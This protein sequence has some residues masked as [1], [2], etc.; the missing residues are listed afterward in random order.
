M[1]VGGTNMMRSEMA[2]VR[3]KTHKDITII[4]ILLVNRCVGTPPTSMEL[5][6]K[7]L[8]LLLTGDTSHSFSCNLIT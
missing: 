3:P 7:A 6:S 4:V 5:P 1:S 8:Y 2:H